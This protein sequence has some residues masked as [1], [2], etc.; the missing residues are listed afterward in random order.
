MVPIRECS[1][2]HSSSILYFSY[3]VV[4]NPFLEV[5]VAFLVIRLC[6]SYMIY[7]IQLFP[8]LNDA[9]NLLLDWISNH[10]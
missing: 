8:R 9:S 4:P 3:A 7:N 6:M 10:M 1:K 5:R 2:P